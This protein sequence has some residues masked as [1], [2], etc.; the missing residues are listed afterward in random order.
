MPTINKYDTKR[1]L[2]VFYCNMTNLFIGVMYKKINKYNRQKLLRPK[3]LR[4][5]FLLFLTHSTRD[6]E[7]DTIGRGNACPRLDHTNYA[8]GW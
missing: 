5:P 2:C 7:K 6:Y 1:K 3:P 8:G 4:N